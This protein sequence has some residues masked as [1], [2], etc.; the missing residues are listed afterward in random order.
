MNEIEKMY[1]NTGI[2]LDCCKYAKYG[3]EGEEGTWYYCTKENK[4]CYTYPDGSANCIEKGYPLF[5]A[6]KQL[7]LIE[8]FISS[9]WW[10]NL[11]SLDETLD[12]SLNFE[13]KLAKLVN[14]LWQEFTKEQQ[15]QVKGILEWV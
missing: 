9:V 11:K 8:F 10:L 15:R 3:Y 12:C 7:E 13:N 2:K 5:T 14:R 6:E 4:E 1:E